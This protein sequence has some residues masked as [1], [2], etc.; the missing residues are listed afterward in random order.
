MDV[1]SSNPYLHLGRYQQPI[2]VP[3]APSE[4]NPVT[5]PEFEKPE[6]SPEQRLALEKSLQERLDEAE[7]KAQEE[8]DALRG[9]TVG[10]VGLQSKKT[11]W[12]IYMSVT[13]QTDMQSDAQDGVAFYRTLRDIQEQNN[14]IKAYAAYR[15]NAVGV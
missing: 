5:I 11:Q 14:T 1:S 15:E 2:T 9:L 10:Y 13:T 6:L 12:E 4:E 3:G 7:E 8:Q